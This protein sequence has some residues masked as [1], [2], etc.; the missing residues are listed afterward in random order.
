MQI[1]GQF[2]TDLQTKVSGSSARDLDPNVS[3]ALRSSRSPSNCN[4]LPSANN[5]P[6]WAA[7]LW[8]YTYKVSERGYFQNGLQGPQDPSQ[9]DFRL[10]T[11]PTSPYSRPG[12]EWLQIILSTWCCSCDGTAGQME[13][14]RTCLPFGKVHTPTLTKPQGIYLRFPPFHPSY[15]LVHQGFVLNPAPVALLRVNS[16]DSWKMQS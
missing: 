12:Q 8:G 11:N 10:F 9:D 5:N 2:V 6:P 14:A 1:P 7:R 4:A 15:V 3:P 16:L 13:R